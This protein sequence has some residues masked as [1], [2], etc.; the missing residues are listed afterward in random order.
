LLEELPPEQ[1]RPV[2]T[3]SEGNCIVCGLK[4]GGRV[5][6]KLMI[7]T[8]PDSEM[9][10]RYTSKG[11]FGSYRT[12]I[13]GAM[14]GILCGRGLIKKKGV[15]RPELC[16]PPELYIGEQVKVGMEVEE[17]TTHIL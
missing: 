16:V 11:A 4:D 12:G 17:S 10:R 3:I 8:S 5:E 6:V 9:H 15:Y 14:A 2:H 7:R 13:C 1:K